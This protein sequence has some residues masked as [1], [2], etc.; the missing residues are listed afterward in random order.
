MSDGS[1][2]LRPSSQRKREAILAAAERQFLADGYEA[3]TMDSI[4]AESLAAKQTLYRHFGSKRALFLEL[5]TT[6]TSAA[7]ARVHSEWPSID[8]DTDVRALLTERLEAQLATVLTPALLSLRRLVIG[9][10]ARFPELAAALYDNGPRHAIDVLAGI[11]HECDAH[12]LL[13]APDPATAAVQ[14]NWLVMGEP[15]NAAM[16]LGAESVPSAA[17]QRRHVALALDVFLAGHAPAVTPAP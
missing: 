15:V 9:E 4:A 13:V 17:E 14:L 7:G 16:L 5:V 11:L 12:G 6:Q 8:Q 2:A 1:G 3:V 10:Q